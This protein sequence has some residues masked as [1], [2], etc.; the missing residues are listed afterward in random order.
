[1]VPGLTE[2]ERSAADVRRLEW[3]A[4]A[5]VDPMRVTWAPGQPTTASAPRLTLPVGLW[6]SGLALA[7]GNSQRLRP[8]RTGTDWSLPADAATASH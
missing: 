2:R 6:R 8:I 1:M 3:L 4:G 5:M 7:R